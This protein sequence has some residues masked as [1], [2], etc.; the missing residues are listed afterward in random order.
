MLRIYSVILE[1]IPKIAPALTAIQRHDPD[2]ARQGRRALTSMPLNT[3][4]GSYS[5]GRNRGARYN[6]AAASGNELIAVLETSVA[7][8]YL[9][10]QDPA[11]IDTLRRIVG[12]LYKNT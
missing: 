2:L 12:T 10:P 4:E 8:G 3:A 5:R 11:V 1:V 6:T 7:M 9:E